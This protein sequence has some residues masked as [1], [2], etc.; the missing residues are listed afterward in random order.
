M[1]RL[2]STLKPT[3]TTKILI[4]EM[5]PF[6]INVI[7][8]ELD[9]TGINHVTQCIDFTEDWKTTFEAFNPHIVIA[10]YD[11]IVNVSANKLNWSLITA[12]VPVICYAG[13]IGE[14][15]A[16]QLIKGG[17]ADIVFQNNIKAL[18]P[19][20]RAALESLK[21]TIAD[22]VDNEHADLKCGMVSNTVL[23][24]CMEGIL[25]TVPDGGILSANAAAC[26]MFGMSEA[27]LL[28]KDRM[29]LIDP[30]DQNLQ[31]L[32]EERR[33]KGKA[34]G[35]IRL[36]RKD[37]TVFPAI[38]S[39]VLF[40]DIDG[41]PRTALIFRDISN[42]R[43]SEL[44]LHTTKNKLAEAF[45]QLN[46]TLEASQDII[47]SFDSQARFVSVNKAC[48]TIWG[49]TADELIGK[50]CF[51]FVL[52]EDQNITTQTDKSIKEGMPVTVFENRYVH[53]SGK[54]VYM[55]W[56]AIWDENE[57]LSYATAKDITN[58]KKLQKTNEVERKRF[59]DLYDLAPC[60]LGI[61][62]GP[63]HIFEM[64]NPLYLQLINRGPDII[65]KRVN[66]VLPELKG[67]G[68]FE[69]LD[70][71]YNTGGSFVANE[72]LIQFDTH[73]DNILSDAYL[74]FMYLAHRNDEGDV[75]GILFF[76]IDV[77]EQ[78]VSR[79]KIEESAKLYHNLIMELPV[80]AYSCDPQGNIVI[81]NK[82]AAQLWGREPQIGKDMWCGSWKMFAPDGKPIPPHSSPMAIALNEG[83]TVSG[84]EI[85]IEHETGERRNILPH[86]IPY[87][88]A[89][90]EITGAV[91][92]LTDITDA[93]EAE[94]SL[95]QQNKE[96]LKANK[97]LDRFV[98]SVSHDLRS[99][100]TS[101]LGIAN[102]IADES[103]EPET[104]AHIEMIKESVHRL[105]GFIRKILSYSQNN[106][107]RLDVEPIVINDKILCIIN[108]LQHMSAARH[109]DYRIDI[110]EDSPFGSD[111]PRFNAILENLISNAIKYQNPGEPNKYIKIVGRVEQNTFRF[112]VSD[113]GI[114]IPAEYHDKIFD[115]FFR[116]SGNAEGSGIGLYIVKDM[117]EQLG[118]T[119]KVNAQKSDVTQFDVVLKN[120]L[121]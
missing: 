112:S 22:V 98:Y 88:N 63:E 19:K 114:G 38:I 3:M 46:K 86:A 42:F 85:I 91:T 104:I 69:L 9:T 89:A 90:N 5:T 79:L 70:E 111:S 1:E 60:C 32:L 26:E 108:S 31:I 87:F 45:R 68:I 15:N 94:M 81:Y 8:N 67:Q 54:V 116:I 82:A 25:L 27:E 50:V 66:E 20:I 99:P 101:I 13:A 97:E 14:E 10:A 6:E 64:A 48:E 35:E 73:G 96:L 18:V 117:V 29:K 2:F 118:G 28:A 21:I 107:T 95:L 76:A 103:G 61:L 77:T 52:A 83:R 121:L 75:D 30:T 58:I 100:L 110:A 113:N 120:Y 47:C 53:K 43:E 12:S 57:Q 78:V 71:V 80:A 105:D 72:K 33:T 59:L 109:I 115:M 41:Q 106:R 16:I 55:L 56:S 49:Y 65:G 24:N 74:N 39:S 37:G 7:K 92:M 40:S 4:I 62:K 93:K 119:I 11:C 17:I 51:D 44:Q 23:E 34:K 36:V 84:T 102:F